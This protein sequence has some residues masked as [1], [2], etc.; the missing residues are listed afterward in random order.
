VPQ[1]PVGGLA[2]HQLIHRAHATLPE[3]S[4]LQADAPQQLA[5][6]ELAV[7]DGARADGMVFS[8]VPVGRFFNAVDVYDSNCRK[9]SILIYGTLAASAAV[10]AEVID[11]ILHTT[12]QQSVQFDNKSDDRPTTGVVDADLNQLWFYQLTLCSE[13]CE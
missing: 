2:H 4:C 5:V 9:F 1:H 13:S 6:Q 8:K 11:F 10:R 3:P 7:L 12:T